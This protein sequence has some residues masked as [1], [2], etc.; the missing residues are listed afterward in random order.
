[1]K[2][3]NE[4]ERTLSMAQFSGTY[5]VTITPFREDGAVDVARLRSFVDWQIEQGIHGLIPLGSTGEFLS[6]TDEERHEVAK[7]SVEQAGGRVPVL[8]GTSAESTDDAIRYAREAEAVGADGIMVIPPFYCMP[9][10][11]EIFEHYRRIGEAV[12][13]PI[14]LYN[15]PNA[16]NV[17]MKPDLIARLSEIDNVLYVKESTLEVTR[18]RDIIRACGDRLQV[19]G[20]VLGFESFCDG[21]V[22]W[23]AV[24]SNVMPKAFA[25]LYE[26]TAIEKD[27]DKARA[28]YAGILPVID[29]VF[30]HRYVSGTKT[31]LREM[32]RGVGPARPPRLPSPPAD[33]ETAR[34]IV[35]ELGL[36]A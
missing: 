34:R 36:G 11:E 8:I 6:L 29:F 28:I 12:S 15:N 35:A 1:M 23:V 21:A 33:V 22:G 5:T 3:A 26:A 31:L 9:T 14:M 4:L 30:G 2:N 7:I 32:G 17:D 24:G 13:L 20:G 18:V 16:A 10:E 27:L 19:F 25:A